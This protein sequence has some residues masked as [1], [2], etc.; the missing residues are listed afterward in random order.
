MSP[1]SLPPPPESS[2]PPSLKFVGE[3]V[4][5]QVLS[6]PIT[7]IMV[8]NGVA[9]GSLEGEL[10]GCHD[11]VGCVVVDGDKVG[12]HVDSYRTSKAEASGCE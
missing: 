4:G 3:S 8:G 9:G 11:T 1:S 12:C 7:D 5:G 6:S 10:V 2:T